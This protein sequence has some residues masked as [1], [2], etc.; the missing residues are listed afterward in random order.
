MNLFHA[1][2][3]LSLVIIF[4]SVTFGT[5]LTLVDFLKQVQEKNQSFVGS[6]LTIEAADLRANEGKL[7]FKPNI[8]AEAKTAIDKKPTTNANAQGDQTDY[9]PLYCRSVAT[10]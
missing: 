7:L 9:T 1:R 3:L 8:F 4:P 6:K 5:Q 10:V 2:A